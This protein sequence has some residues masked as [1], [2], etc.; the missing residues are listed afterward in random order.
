MYRCS[1]PA[2]S[3]V[4][5]GELQTTWRKNDK[6]GILIRSSPLFLREHVLGTSGAGWR[7]WLV[8]SMTLYFAG[9]NLSYAS[10]KN[11]ICCCNS[12][13]YQAARIVGQMV[14]ADRVQ[15]FVIVVAIAVS[16][17]LDCGLTWA[18]G[19]DASWRGHLGRHLPVGSR[20]VT[21]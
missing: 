11:R 2:P 7:S 8:P 9:I 13:L 4:Y 1:R 3:Q 17:V 20:P 18:K 19:L 21:S 5:D 14:R 15:C 12:R 16:V 6:L 10:S